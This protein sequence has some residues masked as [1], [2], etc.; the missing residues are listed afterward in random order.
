MIPGFEIIEGLSRNEL[1][2]LDRVRRISTD[3]VL[4]VK[5]GWTSTAAWLLEHE[6][7]FLKGLAI[8]G[9]SHVV[10][11]IRRDG[12]SFLLIEDGGG[13]P[14]QKHIQSG[15]LDFQAFFKLAIQL[16]G[17]LAELHRRNIIHRNINPQSIL[18]NPLTEASE[19]GDFFLASRASGENPSSHTAQFL[20]DLLPYMSPEQTGRMNRTTDYRTDLYSLGATFYEMLVGSPPFSSSDPLELIHCHI[21]RAAVPPAEI[22]SSIPQPVSQIVM[23]LLAKTAEQR[24][25]SAL[26]LR[27]DLEHCARQWVEQRCIAPFL[28]GQRD[29]SD[30]FLVSQKLYGR[31][32]E[33][34]ELLQVFDNVCE[35]QTAMMLVE[36]YSGIGKTS[37][38]QE[39]YK[40]IVRERGY[41][42][43]GKFDQVARSVPYGALIQ[44]FRGLIR[45]LLA[46]SKDRLAAWRSR[47]VA[48]LG[49]N[50]GVITEVIPEI[51]LI[52]GHQPAPAA[53]GA[54][55]AQNRFQMVFQNFVGAIAQKEHPLV[56]FLD[57]LQ[58]ADSATLNLFEPLLTSPDIDHLFLI[59][60]YRDN[61]VDAAHPL[62]RTLGNLEGAGFHLNR[63]A[64]Q[65]LALADLTLLVADTF[66]C[67]A[68]A[69]EP[70]ARLVLEKTG[71]NP[72]FVI[73]F[74]KALQKEGLLEFDYEQGNWGF[75]LEAIA[76]A[77]ITDNV[78]DLM[79]RKI[80]RLSTKAQA[81][82][83]LGACI[84]N[85]FDLATL[86]I[87]S[88]QSHTSA[89]DDL[90][91]AL[92]EGLLL[93]SSR[94]TDVPA[95]RVSA[96]S[97]YAFLHDR[98]Q[99]AAY[100][101]IPAED[102]Q[103]VHLTV[104]RLLLDQ[105]SGTEAEERVFDIVSHLNLGS[106][107]IE[108]E[109][110]Q[111][112]LA[113]L[114]LTAGS[115]AKASTAH[116]NALG[117]LK[118]GLKLL[119]ED[120]WDSE[121][122]LM[123]ALASERAEC[124][125]LCGNFDEAERQF[126]HIL[127]RAQN[128]LDKARVYGL[129]MVQYEN[130]S[131]YTEALACAR[132]SLALFGFSFPNTT[133]EKG[134]AIEAEIAEIQSLLADRSI[135][136]LIEL[137]LMS[138]TEIRMVM[139]ILTAIWSS[140]YISGDPVLA[141]LISATMVRL[142]LTHGNSEE[143][144]YGYVTHAIT[145]GPVREDYES[146]YEFGRLALSVNELFNDAK[147]R[148][149]IHQQFHAHVNLW[150]QPF[151]TCV[152]HAREASRSGLESGDFLYAAYGA[153][154]ES[155]A[156]FLTTEDL[157][158]FVRDCLT[159]LALTKK[160][161]NAG[162]SDA[163]K[164][165]LNWALAL[166]ARTHSNTSLSND[167]F[168]EEEYRKSYGDNPF[169]MTFFF[170][171]K[172]HLY[173]V[174]DEREQAAEAAR[175][176]RQ[177]VGA[178][179]GTI[180]PVLLNFLGGLA[181][182]ARYQEAKEDEQRELMVELEATH[183]SLKVLAENCPENF[184]CFSLMIEAETARVKG[185]A[186]A[187]MAFYEEAI[188]YA[189]ANL[190]LW[191]ETLAAE[192]Y[193]RF[194]QRRSNELIAA[195]YFAEAGRSYEQWG[196]KAKSLDLQN[197]G[198]RLSGEG[199]A[200]FSIGRAAHPQPEL[201]AFGSLDTLT[202]T[203]AAHAIA[204]E[205]VLEDLL[206]KLMKIAIENAGAER[207]VFLRET[208]GH[209]FIEAEGRVDSDDVR[210]LEAI[211]IREGAHLARGVVYYVHK[212]GEAVVIGDALTDERFASD[213]YV[214][215]VRPRSI[216]CVPVVYQGKF[217]GILYLENNLA[218][219][220]FTAE[221]IDVLRILSSQAAISLES[222]RLYDEMKQ[223]VTQRRRAEETL[224]QIVEGTAAVT[225]GDFFRS[226]VH[227]LA[228]VLSAR[229]VFVTECVDRR[230]TKA[231]TLAFWTGKEFAENV[232]YEVELTPC[233]KVYEGEI[234]FYAKE[235]Q[236]LFPEDEPL[237]DMGVE[238]YIGIPM[239]DAAG[240]V[241]GHL[242]VMDDM[243]MTEGPRGLS[244]LKIFAA[245]AGAEL[246]RLRAYEELRRALEENERLKN[247]LHAENIYLQEE[248]RREHNFEEI[249][250]SSAP[251]IE[252]L[253]KVEQVAPTDTTVL[254]F[255][256]TG[257]GKELIARA[258]H[259][260]SARASRPL[261][262]VNCGAIS[263]GL[264]ESELFGHVKGAF[265]GA[266]ERRVGRFELA[267]GGT[268][269]LDEVGELPMETQ[270][271]LLRVLQESEFEPVGSSRTVRVDVRIIAATNR[272]LEEAVSEGRFR[273][274]LF[275][276]LNVVQ[277]HVPALRERRTDIPQLVMFFLSRFAKRFGNK[278][279]SISQETIDLLTNYSWPGNIRELQNIIERAVVLS[280]SSVLRLGRDLLPTRARD[281]AA[282][283]IETGVVLAAT[284]S[285]ASH[286][287]LPTLEEVERRH[288]LAAL[289]QSNGVVEGTKGA[290]KILDLHPN[291][292]RSR[293]KKLGIQR[294]RY[295][296]S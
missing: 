4:L 212:T 83:T 181:A 177:V 79:T 147:R 88:R 140:T 35:G 184:L 89:E 225:G 182:A 272:S 159:N 290:A 256:E 56:M 69:V 64:L 187:A 75:H 262:K 143:S 226:M 170:I 20:G 232:E 53:L 244:I 62:V 264:V 227:H 190:S 238:S 55:E 199:G 261:V 38:I 41:F 179:D 175:R 165:M 173:L 72:F 204:S 172:L 156:S 268:L 97:S 201:D 44:A 195:V 178:L 16:C 82:L 51:E 22:D 134:A 47:L 106:S 15:R 254:V 246:E 114:N 200:S 96:N 34:N 222:A 61:E 3:E 25:Q 7:N 167:E 249:V 280:Q 203:K 110:E 208:D 235:L 276:R 122:E 228:S 197:K 239:Y 286:Q 220:V 30:R 66:H 151:K 100:A 98:V 283:E 85:Q 210:V 287:P 291:T 259:N 257:T 243:A 158:Q 108:R 296:I 138:D 54:S 40:P 58:W 46:E 211:P 14:L 248:I 186:V 285:T 101:L 260:L 127:E 103:I 219:D 37:L 125:Y 10:D 73:Q 273:S 274:D 135:A 23:R 271:K 251:L 74:L 293:M 145:V 42:I 67:D 253:R 129:R 163:L 118:A 84:G 8:P 174:F 148:A 152:A 18:L 133:E 93:P 237:V 252:A 50:A 105:L 49:A 5:T 150:R 194:W 223:E 95:D 279:D 247:R 236:K 92:E 86:A 141:R 68:A 77:G 289:T 137:P 231:R 17:T 146:A 111:V 76:A 192:L 205:I 26:G 171:L 11:L 2:A 45:Q 94:L 104:G 124:E 99:Q 13:A 292:L 36:G 230:K 218:A 121:Y 119:G 78:V 216:L 214:A 9:I 70:L 117:Y 215:R 189:R 131:R 39:L 102:K 185:H 270:V 183:A 142:S 113:R 233:K 123:L 28:L 91:E 281:F 265:T 206:R 234:C 48:T 258:I 209:L 198:S 193:A 59:G 109:S 149:K 120:K 71:G 65:P 43:A 188:R 241:I 63:I 255:G 19:L 277:I 32:R 275:Y 240:E 169:F 126:E 81:A 196:A 144:A 112:T 294:S 217:E 164:L 207:G 12:D 155:W 166:A 52:V 288:I 191:N 154:T 229:Y 161:R 295:D 116:Q 263:A 282:T 250:G 278:I 157:N 284:A 213:L 168:D 245:R 6:F 160:L 128:K 31:D 1:Y 21:A 180:W 202:V 24:Y 29:V 176:A 27:N 224:T 115:K 139:N 90:R 266:I 130:M 33:V 136:S 57:D 221:R 162:F 267:D 269:F 107:L 87:V 242:V 153:A 60:A 80:Q 132:E